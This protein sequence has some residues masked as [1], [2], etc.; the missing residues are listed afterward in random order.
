MPNGCLS[1]MHRVMQRTKCYDSHRERVIDLKGSFRG[2]M[3]RYHICS[4]FPRSLDSR[5]A[6]RPY[7]VMTPATSTIRDGSSRFNDH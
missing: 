4:N 7:A 3:S 1:K 6:K 5:Q 2:V